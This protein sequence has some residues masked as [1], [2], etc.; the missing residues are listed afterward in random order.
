MMKAGGLP[1]SANV[2]HDFKI[3]AQSTPRKKTPSP[4]TLRLTDE[5]REHLKCLSEGMTM[6]AYIRKCVFGNKVTRRKRRVHTVVKDQK[7]IA[8]ILGLL[9][10]THMA[11]NLNQLAYQANTGSLLIDEESEKEI[12][13][14]CAHIAWMRVKLIEALGLKPTGKA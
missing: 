8:N 13:L 9:G 3:A 12:K 6:S 4:I 7:A 14:A 5:E 2:Q 1:N 10:N 11:N